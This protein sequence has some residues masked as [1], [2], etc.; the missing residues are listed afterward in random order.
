MLIYA[1]HGLFLTTLGKEKLQNSRYGK[2]DSS[3]LMS[4][5]LMNTSDVCVNDELFVHLEEIETIKSKVN[6]SEHITPALAM[7][8]MD[9]W[10]WSLKEAFIAVISLHDGVVVYVTSSM[11]DQLG[12]LPEMWQGRSLLDFLHPKDRLTFT[13]QIT[14]KLMASLDK[15]DSSGY[16]FSNSGNFR[17]AMHRFLPFLALPKMARA[18]KFY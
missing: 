8:L 3:S 5:S 2:E 13:N 1:N 6:A 4:S 11:K 18:W 17:L 12:Y 14:S 16:S 10:F 7:Y 15:D 9:E